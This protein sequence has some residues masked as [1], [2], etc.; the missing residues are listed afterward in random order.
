METESVRYVYQPLDT[1]Y[2]LLI[3]TKAGFLTGFSCLLLELQNLRRCSK[4]K[5]IRT[6]K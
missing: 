1:L 5:K 6:D 2:M 4:K 3:T